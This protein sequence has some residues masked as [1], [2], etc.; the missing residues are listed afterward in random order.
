M[1][2][3]VTLL[4]A[5]IDR[6]NDRARARRNR[7]TEEAYEQHIAKLGAAPLLKKAQKLATQVAAL[8]KECKDAGLDLGGLSSGTPVVGLN[9]WQVKDNWERNFKSK[10]Q[11]KDPSCRETDV[12]TVMLAAAAQGTDDIAKLLD[13]LGL[14]WRDQDANK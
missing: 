8:E 5:A 11:D 1:K 9:T 7:L 3:P 14:N 4:K 10:L 13:G 12:Q 6:H 2:I